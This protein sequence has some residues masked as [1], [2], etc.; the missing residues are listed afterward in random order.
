MTETTISF[1]P[2]EIAQQ[3]QGNVTAFILTSIAFQHAHGASA[4]EYVQFVGQKFAPGWED[5][6]HQPPV[7]VARAATRNFVACGAVLQRF[8]ADENR[9]DVVL[10]GWPAEEDLIFFGLTRATVA[11]FYNIFAPIADYL[12]L[13]YEWHQAGDEV[14]MTFARSWP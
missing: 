12:G 10:I 1:T 9:A 3:N 4:E 6:K 2:A 13:H 11:P 14:T 7:E 5:L 8:T